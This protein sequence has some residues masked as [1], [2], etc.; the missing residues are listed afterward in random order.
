MCT[1]RSRAVLKES[2]LRHPISVFT[3]SVFI[4]LS[5]IRLV[6]C[7][8]DIIF[9]PAQWLC[10]HTKESKPNWGIRAVQSVYSR[11][12]CGECKCCRGIYDG[13]CCAN[14]ILYDKFIIEMQIAIESDNR[15]A[16]VVHYL[17]RYLP[18]DLITLFL[19]S[20]NNTSDIFKR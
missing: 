15:L 8:R 17:G 9:N 1:H 19:S 10:A 14:Q 5:P 6:R 4:Q 2:R 13:F 16:I 3:C 18:W 20:P 11:Y 12:R 7:I